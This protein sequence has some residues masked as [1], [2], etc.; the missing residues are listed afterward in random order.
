MRQSEYYRK[1]VPKLF[2]LFL[3]AVYRRLFSKPGLLHAST[4]EASIYVWQLFDRKHSYCIP[5]DD[6]LK[7]MGF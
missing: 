6:V 7:S 5:V 1:D 3:C 2:D 4:P